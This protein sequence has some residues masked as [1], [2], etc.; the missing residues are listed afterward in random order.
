MKKGSKINLHLIE[1]VFF[2]LHKYH[3][4]SNYFLV[5]RFSLAHVV[6]AQ[7]R[8]M[9]FFAVASHLRSPVKVVN[10]I[11]SECLPKSFSPTLFHS[12]IIT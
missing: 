2:L 7:L 8:L 1:Y 5:S 4:D 9:D 12:T 6:C 11:E 3:A 10:E